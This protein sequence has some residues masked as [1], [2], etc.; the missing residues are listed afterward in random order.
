M[1]TNVAM[2]REYARELRENLALGNSTEH[3]HRPALKTLIEAA[4]D[5]ATAT[6]R[7]DLKAPVHGCS[8][9]GVGVGTAPAGSR[10]SLG[11]AHAAASASVKA[12]TSGSAAA[13]AAMR[14]AERIALRIV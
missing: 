1:P 10:I 8:P 14:T 12:R 6:N 11:E 7:G 13:R 4:Y 3:T 9:G 2:F 5:G